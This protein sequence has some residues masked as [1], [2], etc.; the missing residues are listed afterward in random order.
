MI[1]VLALLFFI[2][3][4]APARGQPK[5]AA[6]KLVLSIADSGDVAA[7]LTL[8]AIPPQGSQ[9]DLTGFRFVAL[10]STLDTQA[11]ITAAP[12]VRVAPLARGQGYTLLAVITPSTSS[13]IQIRIERFS[14]VTETAEGK[15]KLEFD[16]SRSEERRVGKE[17]R[18]RW[19]PYH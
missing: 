1:L 8:P 13:D 5:E 3:L 19:S 12:D 2:P 17:C 11:T 10:P 16:L 4:L 9:K 7:A 6:A 18:S 14:R 15:A